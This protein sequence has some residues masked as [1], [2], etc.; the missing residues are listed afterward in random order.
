[1]KTFLSILAVCALIAALL[2]AFANAVDQEFQDIPPRFQQVA[3]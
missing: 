1:M 2:Q 3:N